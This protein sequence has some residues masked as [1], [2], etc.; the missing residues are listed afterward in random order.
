MLR[1]PAADGPAHGPRKHPR[2]HIAEQTISCWK[3]AALR[4]LSGVL[5]SGALIPVGLADESVD[6]S[7]KGLDLEQLGSIEVIT[8]TKAPKEISRTPAAI[9]VLTSDDIRRSGATSIP[10]VLRLVPGVEVARTDSSTWSVGI[11]G[12]GS[13][14]SRS[15]LVLIDGRSVYTPLYAGVDWKLQ[16]VLLEDVDRIEVIRGPGGTIWGANAVNGVINIITKSAQDTHGMLVSTGGGNA[17]QGFV[18]FRFGGGNSKNLDYRIYGKG[19]TR[20]PQFH[21]DN[22]EFDDWRMGQGGL[23]ADWNLRSSDKLT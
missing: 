6:G 23:R 8:V 14:F 17:D 10:E 22:H 2:K 1:F 11:R 21:P 4:W 3:R 18:G 5:V 19:F 13:T 15:V 20:G 12:F 7:L 9:Y 16:N